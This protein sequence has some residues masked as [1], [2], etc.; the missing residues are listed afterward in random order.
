MGAI[1]IRTI[2]YPTDEKEPWWDCFDVVEELP[3]CKFAIPFDM[4]AEF[5]GNLADLFEHN[6]KMWGRFGGLTS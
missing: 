1:R 5:T 2:L 4:D 6:P 3:D